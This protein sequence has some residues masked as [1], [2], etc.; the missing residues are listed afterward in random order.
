MHNNIETL[1]LRLA[2]KGRAGDRVAVLSW[3]RPEF[4]ELIY[5]VS[6]AGR[7]LVPVNTRL[8][9]A[10]VNYQLR[11][12]GATL[13]FS[14]NSLLAPLKQQA[15]FP[16]SLQVIDLNDD[17]E[18]WRTQRQATALP[19]VSPEDTVWILFTSGSTG[20]PK[21]ARLSH[22]SFMAGLR[23]AAM[24]RPVHPDDRYYYPFPL[25]HVSAHNVLLQHL[26]GAGVVLASA[27]DADATLRACRELGVTSLS[28]APTMI[29]RLLD[30]AEFHPDHL[31][32]VHTIGYGASA[33][34]KA[35]LQSL[36]ERTTVDLCQSYG[37]TELSGSVAFL[38]V[39][40]HQL[41][42]RGRPELLHSV[43]RP[44]PTAKLKLVDT[45]GRECSTGDSGEI[46]VQG[47]QCMEGY[48][49]DRAA[50]DAALVNGW[51]HTG[52][53][54][55]FDKEGY[56]YIVDRKKD[57]IISGGENIASREVEEALLHHDTV[58]NCAVIG[59]PDPHWG[60]ALCAVLEVNDD[61]ADETLATHCRSIV[62]GFKV[63]KRW[64]RVDKLPLNAAGKIDK[65]LLRQR[66]T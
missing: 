6:A 55:R 15:D 46:L 38:T 24:A 57:M 33:M 48:Y 44:L 56:L 27:F 7:I 50:T 5:A 29:R 4:I 66:Y 63:P 1:A 65:P 20:R 45:E 59:L 58:R 9:A 28:L 64:I 60:E 40:D 11:A 3:N 37:M 18:I 51:L 36:M 13:L 22:R 30:H 35:L 53:I 25:F 31:A 47:P 8:A 21:G 43:G 61:I 62:A 34:P 19:H 54:G 16:A 52:D 10:E 23:S 41:A 26:Y 39:A 32:A 12:T 49:N 17:F 2:A 14:E 42:A